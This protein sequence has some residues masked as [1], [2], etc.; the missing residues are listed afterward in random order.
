MSLYDI[1]VP[2][3]PTAPSSLLAV[4]STL[5]ALCIIAVL[6]RFNVR[7]QQRTSVMADDWIMVPALMLVI[8]MGI[9]G[10]LG[11]SLP[12]TFLVH[13]ADCLAVGVKNEVWGYSSPASPT[14]SSVAFEGKVSSNPTS[15]KGTIMAPCFTVDSAFRYFS[16]LSILFLLGS[17][18]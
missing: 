4:S 6:L 11:I 16:K 15:R 7:R 14:E 13:E 8:G 10:I 9:C 18:A 12:L 1:K 2:S 3:G 5:P 17:R